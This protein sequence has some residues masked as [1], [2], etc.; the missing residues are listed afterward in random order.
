MGFGIVDAPHAA[1]DSAAA[2]VTASSTTRDRRVVEKVAGIGV[3]SIVGR[4]QQSGSGNV[5]HT[6]G[7]AERRLAP[8]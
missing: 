4:N 2:P 5:L 3:L 6:G 1:T 7:A 8:D